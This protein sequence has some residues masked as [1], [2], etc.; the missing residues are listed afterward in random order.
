MGGFF[1][2][3][4]TYVR[5]AMNLARC[6][7]GSDKSKSKKFHNGATKIKG[8]HYGK[9]LT[10]QTTIQFKQNIHQT[11]SKRS[12]IYGSVIWDWIGRNVD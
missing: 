2:A 9:L 12:K 5:R 1:V 10:T 6:L 3:S 8:A 7:S 4:A 11:S